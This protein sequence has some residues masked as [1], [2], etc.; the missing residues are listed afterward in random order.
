MKFTRAIVTLALA[1]PLAPNADEIQ[2]QTRRAWV[3][4]WKSGVHGVGG[5][6]HGGGMMA[7]RAEPALARSAQIIYSV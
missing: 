7:L 2:Q 3:A 5:E 1:T 4:G 6:F